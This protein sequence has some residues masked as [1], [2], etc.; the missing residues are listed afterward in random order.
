MNVDDMPAGREMDALVAE[1]VMG[2]ILSPAK[3]LVR[4]R[5]AIAIPGNPIGP[6]TWEDLDAPGLPRYSTDIAA[7][8]Q[9]VEK[10]FAIGSFFSVE[11]PNNGVGWSCGITRGRDT[12]EYILADSAPLAICRA[13]LLA[14]AVKAFNG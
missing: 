3:W 7:A 5:K 12:I 9:V 10:L 8:W 6:K 11:S 13:A 14:A 4:D 1:K 2:W